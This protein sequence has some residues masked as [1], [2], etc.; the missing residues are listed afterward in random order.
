M[1]KHIF[2]FAFIVLAVCLTQSSAFSQ[3]SNTFETEVKRAVAEYDVAWNKKDVKAVSSLLADDYVYFTSLGGTSDRKSTIEFLSSPDYKLTFVERSE[4]VVH[5]KSGT[6][7]VSSRWKG[8]GTWKEG[9][10]NDDQ[11]CGQVFIKDKK[12]WK[13]LA[14]HCV[15]IASK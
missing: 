15:Q 4:I 7:V 5:T 1:H 9:E 10:I 8:K 12:T 3:S 2:S 6:A 14:E 13:L 11:R